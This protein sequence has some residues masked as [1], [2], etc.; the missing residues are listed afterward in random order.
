MTAETAAAPMALFGGVPC[1]HFQGSEKR[2]Q[3]KAADALYVCNVEVGT[4]SWVR[5]VCGLITC[6]EPSH[7]VVHAPLRLAY[8]HGVCVYC[9]R[10]AG[11]RDHLMPR[12]WT[13]DARRR[14]TVTVPACGM[15]NSLLSDTITTS[16]TERRVLAHLRLRR[17]F[18]SV[19][20]TVDW[21]D[22]ELDEF[23]GSLRDHIVQEMARKQEVLRML[24]WPQEGATYD[25]RALERSGI[26][27][28]YVIG[29]I[30][31]DDDEDMLEHVR[32]LL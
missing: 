4:W 18:A 26:D 5:S 22:A 31:A 27:D 14:F 11:T 21:T 28:P 25:L 19:L 3:E 20:R 9:G 1:Q 12:N 15:C 32:G 17:R 29:L 7:L 13:G 24:S 6:I 2:Y 10:R 30:L 16:I 8:P 23:E